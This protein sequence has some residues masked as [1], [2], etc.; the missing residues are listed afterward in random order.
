MDIFFALIESIISTPEQLTGDQIIDFLQWI[1]ETEPESELVRKA[2]PLAYAYIIEDRAKNPAIEERWNSV[3][4]DAKVFTL[5]GNWVK[6]SDEVGV[7]F[8]D[9]G[10]L[11][12]SVIPKARRV[13]PTHLGS[14]NK[15]DNQKSAAALL[16][17]RLV[18]DKFE[19]VPIE[20]DHLPLPSEWAQ[21]FS[22]LYA[23]LAELL[24]QNKSTDDDEDDAETPVES[25]ATPD[26]RTPLMLKL[27]TKLENVARNKE[28]A[29]IIDRKA[30]AATLEGSVAI[31]SGEPE[32]FADE[33]CILVFQYFDAARRQNLLPITNQVTLLLSQIGGKKF[34]E[35]LNKFTKKHGLKEVKQLV[36]EE[37]EKEEELPADEAPVPAESATTKP[38]DVRSL[39][40]AFEEDDADFDNPSDDFH[41]DNTDDLDIDDVLGF[42]ENGSSPKKPENTQPLSSP[43]KESCAP[44]SFAAKSHTGKNAHWSDA[45]STEAAPPVKPGRGKA[46][47]ESRTHSPSNRR[48]LSYVQN[49][50]HES[51]ND[52][53][54]EAENE[55]ET[56]VVGRAGEMAAMDFEQQ[57]GWTPTKMPHNNPGYDIESIGPNGEKIYIEV[58][59]VSGEWSE[60]GVAVSATQ[61]EFAQ[62]NPES[63]WLY[64]VENVGIAGEERVYPILNPAKQ[65]TEFR[66]DSGWKSVAQTMQ[67]SSSSAN[68]VEVGS[69][70]RDLNGDSRT[71]TI[72]EVTARGKFL[73]V[74]ILFDDDT[75]SQTLFTPDRFELI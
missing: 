73:L 49:A 5:G 8:D 12:Y 10:F 71:G 32:D 28:T 24:R 6:T 4:E 41:T 45:K 58:K 23:V 44:S 35:R 3:I 74:K 39:L 38:S 62:Q 31:V 55:N 72:T 15:P 27:V 52:P 56:L 46:S 65:V 17:V 69:R 63:T 21:N 1:W 50:N 61:F 66:F 36:K 43:H 9:I 34:L 57:R 70:V 40:E 19:I 60:S 33:L 11:N 18:S 53:S 26:K 20:G 54:N 47:S 48:L 37:E 75:E 7:F 67:Q 29:E 25:V 64:V 14:N 68:S 42:Y 51:V 30:L 2:L 16:N 22:V 59:G 13:T